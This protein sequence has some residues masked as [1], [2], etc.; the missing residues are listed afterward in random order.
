MVQDSSLPHKLKIL[1][2]NPCVLKVGRL[3]KSNIKVLERVCSASTPFMGIIGLGQYAMD[4]H[5]IESTQSLGL[6]NVA[7]SSARCNLIERS[8][9]SAMTKAEVAM[10]EQ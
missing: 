9:R 7:D 2:S 3:I 10:T 1:L 6:N 8:C 4:W 5:V